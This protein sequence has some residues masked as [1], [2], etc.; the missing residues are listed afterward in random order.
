MAKEPIDD[1]D[2][3]VSRRRLLEK[4]ALAVGAATVAARTALARSS[5]VVID[6]AGRVL[7]NG[8]ALPAQ[9]LEGCFETADSTNA[10]SCTNGS[11][12]TKSTNAANCSN[13][14]TCV[15]PSRATQSRQPTSAAPKENAPGGGG[16]HK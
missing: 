4:A 13:Q 10:G 9:R 5:D 11:S 2:S 16:S 15:A 12:C 14:K 3:D 7:I 1:G 8:A 6:S